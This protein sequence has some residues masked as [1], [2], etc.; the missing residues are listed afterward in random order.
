MEKSWENLVYDE[1]SVFLVN[2]NLLTK[3]QSGFRPGDSSINQL[4]SITATIFENYDEIRAV[5]LDISKAFEA[6]HDGLS[7]S[8]FNSDLSNRQQKVVL[9]GK[10]SDWKGIEPGVPQGSVS[11]PL[12]FFLGTFMISLKT[13]YLP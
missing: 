7:S 3:H 9:N 2:N 10:V 8:F 5:F 6:W 13:F 1:L 4:L 12:L 11:G